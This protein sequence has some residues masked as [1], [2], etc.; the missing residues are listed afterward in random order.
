MA[1]VIDL[2]IEGRAARRPRRCCLDGNA[3]MRTGT[4]KGVRITV[5]REGS[6]VVGLGYAPCQTCPKTRNLGSL[7]SKRH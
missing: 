7:T 3:Q 1:E 2:A 5:A 4:V 6:R